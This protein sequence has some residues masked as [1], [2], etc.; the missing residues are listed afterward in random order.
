MKNL[1]MT[2]V[3]VLSAASLLTAGEAVFYGGAQK[4]GKL[5]FDGASE[6]PQ[7]LLE[8]DF[9]ATM[10]AR[11]SGGS[12]LGFE[13]NISFSPRFAKQGVKAFQMDSNLILQVP[14]RVAPYAT[15]GI[16]FIRTWSPDSD[17]EESLEDLAAAAFGFGTK[18]TANYGVGIKLRRLLGPLGFN[19][20]VRG[21]RIPNARDGSLHF[22]QTTAGFVISW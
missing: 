19:I 8:G 17:P 16:G 7:E 3:F 5:T 12:V 18:F 14:G 13:Q 21:Y 15:A 10:G 4:P 11:F 6:A 2:L 22:T 20:D 1:V 9:G